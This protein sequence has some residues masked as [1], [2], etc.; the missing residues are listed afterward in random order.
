MKVEASRNPTKLLQPGKQPLDL[1]ATFVAAQSSAVL[2]CSFLPIRLVRRN[3]LDT[4]FAQLF[5]ERVGVISFVSNQPLREFRGKALNESFSD[6]GDFMRRSRL[7]VDREWKTSRVCH[8]HELRAFAPLGLS[9]FCAP[10]LATMNVPSMKHSLRSISPRVRRSSARASSMLRSVPSRDHC[11]KRRWQ[12]WYGGNLSGKSCQRAPLRR[13]QSTPFITSR[14]SFHGR[15]RPS[16]RRGGSGIIG[17]I[18]AH[19]SSVSSSPR[20]F[21]MQGIVA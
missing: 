15:P 17:S 16:S 19:C 21:A 14:V 3:H 11:W 10:F 12:V 5:I 20:L 9:H 7:C 4:L 2:R 18:I 1:P 13:I 8:C 6:K